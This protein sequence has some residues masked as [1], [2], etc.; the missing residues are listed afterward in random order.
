MTALAERSRW[1]DDRID[2]LHEEVKLLRPIPEKVA[3]LTERM[4]AFR[5][6]AQAIGDLSRRLE[7]RLSQAIV[8]F[9]DE[10]ADHR[11]DER[12]ANRN[13][14]WHTTLIGR[15]QTLALFLAVA[16]AVVS[17]IVAA[18]NHP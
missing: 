9:Q 18:S 8:D 12:H 13:Q 16:V 7:G 14:N 3:T 17:L 11:A 6:D 1:P 4:E 15:L 5:E 2:D 10:Q